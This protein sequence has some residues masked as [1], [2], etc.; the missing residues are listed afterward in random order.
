MA[1]R[2]KDGLLEAV[3]DLV[4]RMPWWAGVGL[5]FISYLL[6]SGLANRPLPP[7]PPAQVGSQVT[8]MM[9]RG[10][11]LAGQY[12]VP[13]LCLVGAGVS[14]WRRHERKGLMHEATGHEPAAAVNRMSWQQFER[15]VG[16][17]FR[18]Q[19]F[20]VTE[21]GQR[22]P[23]G[24]VDLEL[25]RAGETFLVQCK[26]WRAQRVG[27]EIVRELYGVMAA[28]GATGGYV[29]TSG[30]FT[31]E[32]MAFAEGR[33]IRLVDGERLMR[34]FNPARASGPAP[35][36]APATPACPVCSKPML[37]R[38]AKRGGSAGSSFWGCSA[39]PGCRGTRPTD[40]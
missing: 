19:G 27:V 17:G 20:A 13:L 15:L 7:V 40:A 39:Y 22:G 8:G 1:R 21:R 24:G 35:A 3:V 31:S 10:L 28:E 30:R 33:N 16:E 38:T 18:Q 11:A 4:S 29:V 12:L 9:G 23:D 25:R 6:L 14:A 37:R 32:A 36:P 26:Q 2:R 5:A 34:Q